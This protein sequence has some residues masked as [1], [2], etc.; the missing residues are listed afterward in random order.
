MLPINATR[1]ALL[2]VAIPTLLGLVL[3]ACLSTPTRN[4]YIKSAEGQFDSPP[5]LPALNKADSKG[6]VSVGLIGEYKSPPS[7]ELPIGELN[8]FGSDSVSKAYRSQYNLNQDPVGIGFLIQ[9]SPH[10]IFDWFVTTGIRPS[11]SVL[12]SLTVGAGLTVPFPFLNIRVA[13]S[14]GIHTYKTRFVDSVIAR[15]D[16]VTPLFG[17]SSGGFTYDTTV[18]RIDQRLRRTGITRAWSVS[19]W[20]GSN[21]IGPWTPYLQYQ[22]QWI[23]ME[24]ERSEFAIPKKVM[25]L[26][27]STFAVGLDYAFNQSFS[28][29]TRAARE[30]LRNGF[31]SDVYYRFESVIGIRIR[32]KDP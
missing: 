23:G 3:T 30:S 28:V 20:P 2:K 19:I 13:P 32:T 14:L 29:N 4:H 9:G 15:Y 16:G 8:G 18:Y 10:E 12:R 25:N 21:L 26:R 31:G 6:S 1:P 24:A 27:G 7:I 11:F 5:I 17:G 22:T